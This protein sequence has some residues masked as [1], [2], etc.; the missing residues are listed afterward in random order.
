MMTD[1][2]FAQ[3]ALLAE[4]LEPQQAALLR[5]LC[6]ASVNSL[7]AQLRE[8]VTIDDCK[9]DFI[10]AASLYAL[11]A[12]RESGSNGG[13]SELKAGDLTVKRSGMDTSSG[14]LRKQA[15]QIMQPFAA[16]GFHFAGV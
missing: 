5:V 3:A 8:G 2:V 12:L 13:I 11:A 15:E 10:A 1:L 9:A 6:K 4:P 14:S 16:A 7:M